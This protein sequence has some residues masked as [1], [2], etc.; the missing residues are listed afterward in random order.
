M[1]Y[2]DLWFWSHVVTFHLVQ[3]PESAEV[4]LDPSS[5]FML[6]CVR[7]VHCYPGIPT[8]LRDI[9]QANKVHV[10]PA[11][12]SEDSL[13]VRLSRNSSGRNHYSKTL[14]LECSICASIHGA[15][16]L[17]W[18]TL[19]Y[20][21]LS[22]RLWDAPPSLSIA[23]SIHER[24]VQ[25]CRGVPPERSPHRLQRGTFSQ[26]PVVSSIWVPVSSTGIIP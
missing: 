23:G 1:Q 21:Y 17:V 3:V 24:G 8:L 22:L 11:S 14:I 25:T 6:V 15:L 7:N 20:M 26:A 16:F 19:P 18:P 4:H 5:Y 2:T 12:L 9:F 10:C 13:L